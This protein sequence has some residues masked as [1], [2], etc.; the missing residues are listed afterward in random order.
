MIITQYC[1]DTTHVPHK[2]DTSKAPGQL[3]LCHIC[4][5]EKVGVN[6][7]GSPIINNGIGSI[8]TLTSC[9]NEV[10]VHVFII[11]LCY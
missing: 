8:I 3:I 4:V 5:Y 9:T 2:N 1:G 6:K 7:N 11:V 10:D